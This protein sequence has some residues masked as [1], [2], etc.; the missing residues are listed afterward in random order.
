MN[1]T[2]S[3]N[4]FINDNE[5][6]DFSNTESEKDFFEPIFGNYLFKMVSIFT[7]L[8]GWFGIFGM[9]IVI[10]FERS[11]QAGHFRTLVNQLVSFNFDQ[12]NTIFV[13]DLL[14]EKHTTNC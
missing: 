6:L 4:I 8:L 3:S 5:S 7:Y 9:I 11:G 13:S 14:N 1:Q 2:F 12:V 10:H